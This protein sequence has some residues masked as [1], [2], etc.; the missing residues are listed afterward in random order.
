RRADR[1][2][3]WLRL[4]GVGPEQVVGICAERSVEMLV[5]V[6]GILK[7]GG[8][9]LPLDSSY[10]QER[11]S[12]VLKN[13]GVKAVVTQ[14]RLAPKLPPYQVA[15]I[16]LEEDWGAM[17]EERQFDEGVEMDWESPAYVIYTSG[18]TGRPKGVAMVHRALTNL[19]RWQL[20][21]P[22]FSSPP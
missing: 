14:K 2:A 13:S 4:S 8:A 16:W 6:L 20:D 7:A 18:S 11:L 10:P 15:M 5:G 22:Q 3:H 17:E 12:Y 1:I 9:Y 21:Q 19:I